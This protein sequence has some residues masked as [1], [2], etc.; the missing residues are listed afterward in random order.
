M[1]RGGN[2][3]LFKSADLAL[4]AAGA[5]ALAGAA[6]MAAAGFTAT[7][8]LPVTAL[9]AVPLPLVLPAFAL[10]S[11]EAIVVRTGVF[12]LATRPAAFAGLAFT[13][14]AVAVTRPPLA[15]FFATEDFRDCLLAT[16]VPRSFRCYRTGGVP[17]LLIPDA[18]NRKDLQV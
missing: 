11:E 14:T 17:S 6:F 7:G 10:G 5:E 15:G 18:P 4:A 1:G 8:V 2:S 16:V 3:G 12:G 13:L 9:W